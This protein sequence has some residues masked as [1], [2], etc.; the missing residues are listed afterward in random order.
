MEGDGARK[1]YDRIEG[2]KKPRGFGVLREINEVKR[3]E[4]RARRIREG[5]ILGFLE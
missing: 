1:G 4:S 3:L 5:E 2:L